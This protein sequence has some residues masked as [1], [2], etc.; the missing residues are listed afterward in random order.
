MTEW[1]KKTMVP[2]MMFI[3]LLLVFIAGYFTSPAIST[4]PW[5][6]RWGEI[7]PG[8]LPAMIVF[9]I[10]F[11]IPVSIKRLLIE[12]SSQYAPKTERYEL[13]CGLLILLILVGFVL[14]M[15]AYHSKTIN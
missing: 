5:L 7:F 9:S 15:M 14:Y 6:G 13:V 10:S 1:I 3:R 2:F 8:V 4:I 11:L 12:R